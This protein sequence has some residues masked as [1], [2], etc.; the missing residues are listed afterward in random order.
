LERFGY[1]VSQFTLEAGQTEHV[2]TL[3]RDLVHFECAAYAAGGAAEI[4]VRR[5]EFVREP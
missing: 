1:A 4:D 2:L 3:R 5:I